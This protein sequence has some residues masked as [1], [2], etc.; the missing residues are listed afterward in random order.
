MA[1]KNHFTITVTLT[2][3]LEEVTD[4]RGNRSPRQVE[5]ISKVVVRADTAEEAVEKCQAIIPSL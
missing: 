2:E 1:A 5:E 4:N 3:T